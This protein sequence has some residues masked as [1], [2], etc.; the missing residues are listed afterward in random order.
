VTQALKAAAATVGVRFL[1]HLIIGEAA[2]FSF[3]ANGIL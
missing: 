3:K 2:P 1:D